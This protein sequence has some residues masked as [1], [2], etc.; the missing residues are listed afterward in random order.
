MKTFGNYELETL[1]D[2]VL[3]SVAENPGCRLVPADDVACVVGRD[4]RIDG[5]LRDRPELLLRLFPLA[6]VADDAGIVAFVIQK[7]CGQRQLHGKLAAVF[8]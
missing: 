6:Y 7:P 2:R 4:D 3:G 8:P 1:P 5:R